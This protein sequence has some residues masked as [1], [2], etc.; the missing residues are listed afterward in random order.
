MAEPLLTAT[1]LGHRFGA[2]PWLFRGLDLAVE[3]GESLAIL[4]PNGRG[5]STLLQL[6]IQ[7][8]APVEG[9]VRAPARLAFVPQA[10]SPAF[11]FTA[12]DIVL[13]G[14]S[15]SVGLFGQPSA[16]DEAAA[17]GA[18]DALDLGWAA[19]R[20]FQT[21]SGGER[22]LVML[23]RALAAE[24]DLLILDEPTAALDLRHQRQVLGRMRQLKED[25]RSLIFTTHDPTQA[26][27]AADRTLLLLDAADHELGQSA[28]VLTEIALTRLYGVPIRKAVVPDSS[29][30][31]TTFIAGR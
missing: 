12:L 23:A 7:A 14:R 2:A 16:A 30:S 6:L 3:P 29:P 26:L 15:R 11:A 9:D 19:P 21:L 8:R 31:L 13:T 28:E 5:K 1:G 4:G 18:L 22:Q 24:A 10:F 25:G 27:E 17:R 20:P